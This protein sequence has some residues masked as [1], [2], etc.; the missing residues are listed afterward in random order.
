MN[1]LLK[2]NAAKQEPRKKGKESVAG[3]FVRGNM[4]YVRKRINGKLISYSTGKKDNDANRKWVEYHSE[5][6]WQEKADEAHKTVLLNLVS[7]SREYTLEEYGLKFYQL[8]PDTRDQVTHD[9]L[10]DDFVKYAV[11][12]LGKLKLSEI[13]ASHIERWQLQMKYY[14]D[15]IPELSAIDNIKE[16]RG[17][18]RMKNLKSALTMV[19]N[20]AVLDGILTSSPAANVKLKKKASKR[21]SIS[22]QEAEELDDEEIEDIFT[23]DTITYGEAEIR[24][25]I[26]VCDE[27][28][29]EKQR[30]HHRFV[31]TVF[32]YMMIF[33]F[34]SGVRSGEAIALMWKFVDFE[35]NKIRIQFTMRNG[36]LKLSSRP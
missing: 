34:Y 5:S 28:I 23:S 30:S 19:L 8:F 36:K 18:S 16:R 2:L 6:I 10:K 33:K 17:H 14:P 31:W 21:R 12:I 24:Q 25:L 20:Q 4:L 32:K 15:P 13:T 9:R 22:I 29:A 11:P 7:S 3:V 35:K 1:S 27:I 26:L